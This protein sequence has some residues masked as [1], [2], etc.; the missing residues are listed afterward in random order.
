MTDK[1]IQEIFEKLSLGNEEARKKFQNLD[2]NNEKELDV[3]RL[4]LSTHS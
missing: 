2:L 4:G 1:E 3:S